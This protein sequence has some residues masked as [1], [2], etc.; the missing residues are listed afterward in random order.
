MIKTRFC[1]SPTGYM[2][3]GNLRTALFN[4]LLAK[5]DQGTFLLRIE[6]TDQERS[7]QVYTDM[8]CKDLSW[9]GL[10]W[11]EGFDKLGKHGPYAQSQRGHIYAGYYQQLLD[12]GHAYWCFCSESALVIQRKAQLASGKPPK[13]PGTCRHLSAEEVQAKCNEGL[14]PALRFCMPET[15]SISFNDL[16]KGQQSFQCADI[17]DF[18]IKRSDGGAS[19]MFCNAIDDALMEVTHA[20][21]GEDHLT[22]TPRQIA[23]LRA[24][25]LT[26]PQYGHIALIVGDDRTPL[27]KRHGSQSVL[28]LREQGF[29]P[30]ALLNYLGRLGH[31]YASDSLLSRHELAVHFSLDNLGSSSARFDV[32]QLHYWQKHALMVMSDAD[33]AAWAQPHLPEWLPAF[34]HQDFLELT[35]PNIVFYP[36]IVRWAESLWSESLSYDSDSMA[37]LQQAGKGFFEICAKAFM[38]H[39]HTE[40]AVAQIKETTGAKGKAL[41]QPLRVALTGGHAGPDLKDLFTFIGH[42][43]LAARFLAAQ[44]AIDSE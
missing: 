42:Q 19:F 31:N 29:L 10:D 24:L 27:S 1:P 14:A 16:V 34:K 23:I 30:L 17:G 21:R 4:A 2:H 37:A 12:A 33:F 35:R 9:L 41:F 32:A 6:D 25:D 38:T 20:L 7:Q 40:A 22:N 5:H 44:N 43:R 26:P 3:L 28:Q 8:L 18:I 11:Q 36:D 15:G 13:Y 39:N